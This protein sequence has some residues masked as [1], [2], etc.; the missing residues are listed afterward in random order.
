MKT[1]ICRECGTELVQSGRLTWYCPQCD[2][3]SSCGCPRVDGFA[4][5]SGCK[6]LAE[7]RKQ[8]DKEFAA[9]ANENDSASDTRAIGQAIAIA[10]NA[11]DKF[12][13]SEA[14][15]SIAREIYADNWEPAGPIYAG[16]WGSTS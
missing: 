9:W 13:V 6:A 11:A 12:I 15:K 14:W 8:A 16:D 7:A 4:H 2:T 1:G 3:C 10:A 5:N